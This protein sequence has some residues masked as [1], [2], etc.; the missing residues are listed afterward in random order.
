MAQLKPD[1]LRRGII[2]KGVGIVWGKHKMVPCSSASELLP[3]LDWKGGGRGCVGS[4]DSVERCGRGQLWGDPAEG[5]GTEVLQSYSPVPLSPANYNPT[6]SQRVGEAPY[7]L[8]SRGIPR[9]RVKSK[10]W[11]G[12]QKM[13]YTNK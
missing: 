4:Y 5:C 8:S 9:T 1:N 11:R 10:I 7:R 12:N 13:C 3:L 6:R 2:Y